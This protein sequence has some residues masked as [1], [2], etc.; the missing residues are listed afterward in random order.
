[1][2][3]IYSGIILFIEIL[4][5]ICLW[6]ISGHEV[7][8]YP[9]RHDPVMTGFWKNV[10][11]PTYLGVFILSSII[12]ICISLVLIRIYTQVKRR[13]QNNKILSL[14]FTVLYIFSSLKLVFFIYHLY[15]LVKVLF[16]VQ[17]CTP[18]PPPNVPCYFE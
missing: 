13:F 8:L 9:H 17:S 7:I 12:G 18:V 4:D 6:I 2:K 16:S 1:M 11:S 14:I 10:I 3:F 5:L 15:E